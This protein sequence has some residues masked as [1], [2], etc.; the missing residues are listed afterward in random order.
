MNDAILEY[1]EELIP[2]SRGYASVKGRLHTRYSPVRHAC[3][4]QAGPYRSTCM[5]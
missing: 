3:I 1:Y 4:P 2:I 5:Y